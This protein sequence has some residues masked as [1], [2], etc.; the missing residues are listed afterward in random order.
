MSSQ[1]RYTCVHCGTAGAQ[2]YAH[3]YGQNVELATCK[4]CRKAIDPYF[5][6][7]IVHL[8][9]LSLQ[10]RHSVLVHLVQNRCADGSAIGEEA[11]WI[12]TRL[13]LLSS[14]SE[15]VVV[16]TSA[17]ARG[18][19]GD[20]I[21]V[22]STSAPLRGFGAE[23]PALWAET[24]AAAFDATRLV[25]SSAGCVSASPGCIALATGAAS[26]GQLVLAAAFACTV[27]AAT[28][29]G[30]PADALA[31]AHRQVSVASLVSI[32]LA[33][34]AACGRGHVGYLLVLYTA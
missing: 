19:P 26:L 30:G 29:A 32:L 14:V 33:T 16:L 5:E 15:A 25:A 4:V 13:P 1:G 23:L 18:A 17:E 9:M 3:T 11:R 27:F 20:I 31:S 8:L 2:E 34:L 24:E 22:L 7:D 10:Q 6:Y 28:R 21:E 12:M